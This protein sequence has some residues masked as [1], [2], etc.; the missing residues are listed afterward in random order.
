MTCFLSLSSVARA[1]NLLFSP[2]NAPH[3]TTLFPPPLSF[4]PCRPCCIARPCGCSWLAHDLSVAQR[5]LSVTYTNCYKDWFIFQGCFCDVI[6]YI[7]HTKGA[8]VSNSS[9]PPFFNFISVIALSLK[10]D[11]ILPMHRYTYN[12]KFLISSLC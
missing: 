11:Y 10:F 5:C 12:E 4:P 9:H 7:V 2:T 8:P 1:T 6:I 3:H